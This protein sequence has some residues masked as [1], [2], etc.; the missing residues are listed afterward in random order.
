MRRIDIARDFSRYPAGRMKTDGPFSGEL[1]RE[2]FLQ[3]AMEQNEDIELV[4]DGTR[5][6]GSSFLEEAFGGLVRA[7]HNKDDIHRHIKI[8]TRDSGLKQ[9]IDEYIENGDA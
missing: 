7:G 5:G 2:R 3:P 4:M 9:E 1:F 6:Y 8:V